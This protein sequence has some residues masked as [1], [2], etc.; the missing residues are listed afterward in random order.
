CLVRM[1]NQNITAE[2]ARSVLEFMRKN[3][4]EK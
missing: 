2:E 4:G 3:D 1:P